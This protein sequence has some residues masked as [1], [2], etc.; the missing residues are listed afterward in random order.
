M[1]SWFEVSQLPTQRLFAQQSNEAIAENDSDHLVQASEPVALDADRLRME[2]EHGFAQGLKAAQ[3]SAPETSEAVNEAIREVQAAYQESMSALSNALNDAFIVN[4]AQTKRAVATLVRSCCEKVVATE[5]ETSQ[6]KIQSMVKSALTELGVKS[7]VTLSVSSVDYPGLSHLE[8][9]MSVVVDD[10][11][12]RG[13][14][15]LDTPVKRLRVSPQ[16]SIDQLVSRALS[17]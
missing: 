9:D 5:L 8:N 6:R 16:E 7:D 11:L 12:Q 2:F 10:S 17:L 3:A 4:D 1:A 14:F 15:V 13:E